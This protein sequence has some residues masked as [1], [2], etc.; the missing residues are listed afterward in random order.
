MGLN[1][2]WELSNVDVLRNYEIATIMPV[3]S[4]TPNSILQQYVEYLVLTLYQY[5]ASLYPYII[6]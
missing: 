6:F 5:I 2:K 3:T 4:F 1:D